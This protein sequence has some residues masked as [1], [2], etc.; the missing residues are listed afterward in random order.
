MGPE[1]TRGAMG[2]EGTRGAMSPDAIGKAKGAEGVRGTTG[3][4]SKRNAMGSARTL[5]VVRTS[6]LVGGPCC[7]QIRPGIASQAGP[8]Q[9]LI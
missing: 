4:E 7:R 8:P 1:G 6:F 5:H 9:F 3:P 2:P